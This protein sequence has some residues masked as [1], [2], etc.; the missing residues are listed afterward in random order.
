MDNVYLSLLSSI[1]DMND[2]FVVIFKDNK[3]LLTNT[4]FNNFF[5]VSCTE[6]YN[7]RFGELINNFVAHPSYF[8]KDKMADKENW[9]ESILK[10]DE[11][12]RIVS[13]LSKTYEPQ[14]F[15][16][17]VDNISNTYKVVVLKDITQDL[18][19]RIMIQNN[20]NIDANSGAYDRKYFKE[21]AKSYQEAAVFNEKIVSILSIV[22]TK[23]NDVEYKDFVNDLVVMIR[24]DD[25]LVR[26]SENTF[27]L[28]YM[29]E[30]T[31]SAYKV[32]EKFE[33]VINMHP[34][35]KYKCKIK[36]NIKKEDEH[37]NSLIKRL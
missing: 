14:A 13:M 15:K 11:K 9:M 20:A 3:V 2:D 35:S 24:K 7:A 36:L 28:V 18:I 23:E 29:S 8:N 12:D 4:S 19:K 27:F 31:Q 32:L 6:E 21:I 37:I 10:I 16:I 30:N 26:W 34:I 17:H 1:A 22:I 5:N 25:M 33:D